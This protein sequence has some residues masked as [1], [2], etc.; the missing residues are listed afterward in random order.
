MSS[1]TRLGLVMLG[2]L[3]A[4]TTPAV[5]RG[6]DCNSNASDDACDI[7]CENPGCSDVPGCGQ[8]E[9]CN[10]NEV[11]DECDIGDLFAGTQGGG[12]PGGGKV[13]EYEGGSNWTDISPTPGWDVAVVMSLTMYEGKLHAGTSTGYGKGGG[14]GGTG[15][16][17][18]YEGERN[19][20]PLGQLDRSVAVVLVLGN[21]LYAATNAMKL[22]RYDPPNWTL[23]G[24]NPIPRDGGSYSGTGFR[25]GVVTSVLCGTPEIILG[26]LD[27][28]GFFRYTP[29]DG[30]RYLDDWPGSCIWDFAEYDSAYDD[31]RLYGGAWYGNGGP[32]YQSALPS[33]CSPAELAFN[34]IRQTAVNNWSLEAFNGL[35]YVGGG[36]PM[37]PPD[38]P[39]PAGAKLWTF[40]GLNWSGPVFTRPTSINHEGVSALAVYRGALYVGL[41]LPEGYFSG[42]G[43]AEV[44]RTADGINFE[45]VPPSDEFGT[46][47]F[48]GGVQCLVA[49]PGV[50]SDCNNNGIPDECE[51]DADQDGIIDD[52]DNCPAVGNPDQADCD[53]DGEGDAC[54]GDDLDDDGVPDEQDNC[55]CHYN[56]DQADSDCD[57][58]GDACDPTP[59]SLFD[60]D[61]DCDVDQDDFGAMQAC[62][63]GGPS[64]E[65]V[66]CPGGGQP[67]SP[68]FYSCLAKDING[69]GA[70]AGSH[71]DAGSW[72]TTYPERFS[73]YELFERCASG[74]DVR[75]DASCGD[76]DAVGLEEYQS[77]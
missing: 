35:L 39:D 49:V 51:A 59:R 2:G 21:D 38:G 15:Q 43:R 47:I 28:D 17:W 65:Y 52:C 31:G 55:E 37:N 4:L 19:W 58:V 12:L 75:A 20:T 1:R 30:L 29:A 27:H 77:G 69:D 6:D 26:E 10:T 60:F 9:D 64:L 14:S 68:E 62:F 41:G 66:F 61:D 25:S 46:G 63:T 72:P 44:W 40:D 56:P 36:G 50:S 16:V 74:P 23:V 48:G 67:C 70:V 53:G 11:P 3:S 76:C 32:V 8:S 73:D 57:G 54:E 34:S 7:S 13:F 24:S 42:D 71:V 33:T 18:R 22:Y 5:L 45:L